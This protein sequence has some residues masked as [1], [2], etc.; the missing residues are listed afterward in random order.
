MTAAVEYSHIQ[1]GQTRIGYAM[2]SSRA[3]PWRFRAGC[4]A[5]IVARVAKAHV[6]CGWD[7][8]TVARGWLVLSPGGPRVHVRPWHPAR[9]RAVERLE[10]R[11][12]P[13]REPQ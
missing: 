10:R 1:F 11:L 9:Q 6:T 13:V 4:P 7:P 3:L 12:R 8:L 2:L 5:R